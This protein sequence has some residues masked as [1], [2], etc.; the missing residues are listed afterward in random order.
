MKHLLIIACSVLSII[1]CSDSQTTNDEY[2]LIEALFDPGDGS[3]E[4]IPVQSSMTL[5]I[6]ADDT[7]ETKKGTFCSSTNTSISEAGSINYANGTLD[8]KNCGSSTQNLI[9]KKENDLW[10]IYLPCIEP[11]I[12]KFQKQ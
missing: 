11:C 10:M 2:Q 12:L 4:Y 1:S 5:L 3:G 7:Y 9:F 6:Y 8:S